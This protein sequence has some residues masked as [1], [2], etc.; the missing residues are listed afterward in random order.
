MR[1]G[2][3]PSAADLKFRIYEGV[4]NSWRSL[5]KWFSR[6]A[7]TS[8][9]HKRPYPRSLNLKAV[10][11]QLQTLPILLAVGATVVFAPQ[12]S[13][14]APHP[15]YLRAQ[16]ARHL[17]LKNSHSAS[18]ITRSAPQHAERL[19]L[20]H[21]VGP[22]SL[23]HPFNQLSDAI[24]DH[25]A[26]TRSRRAGSEPRVKHHAQNSESQRYA[27]NSAPKPRQYG[28][29]HDHRGGGTPPRGQPDRSE[30]DRGRR[31]HSAPDRRCRSDRRA[32]SMGV[33][34]LTSRGLGPS[35][36]V[37]NC[38]NM[39]RLYQL[40]GELSLNT[41]DTCAIAVYPK[42]R[43]CPPLSSRDRAGPDPSPRKDVAHD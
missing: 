16:S 20:D 43:S 1:S 19:C 13:A 22:F 26:R 35:A 17:H 11:Q 6:A 18:T 8:W 42:R 14:E 39:S 3:R 15:T 24:D 2:S 21:F 4:R 38:H 10:L 28:I 12:N 7:T 29:F 37:T 9:V 23:L 31:S 27:S 5:G 32:R 25:L 36:C 33:F 41:A 34:S 30:V 40:S